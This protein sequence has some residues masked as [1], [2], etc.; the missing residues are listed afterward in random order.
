MPFHGAKCSRADYGFI[1][2]FRKIGGDVDLHDEPADH[3]LN[4][5][6]HIIH[7]NCDSAGIDPSLV[8]ESFN[9][10]S[11]ASAKRGKEQGKRSRCRGFSTGLDRLISTNGVTVNYGVDLFFT[12][13]AC[14][15]QAFNGPYVGFTIVASSE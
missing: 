6:I 10:D 5:I 12:I 9:I 7:V 3:F 8:A 1:I 14:S 4:R 15:A 11:G 13:I 2:L